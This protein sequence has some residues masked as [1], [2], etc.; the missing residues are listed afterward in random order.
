[1]IHI[2]STQLDYIYNTCSDMHHNN[3]VHNIC[4]NF[5]TKVYQYLISVLTNINYIKG[6]PKQIATTYT[7]VG[8]YLT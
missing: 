8:M 3:G 2:E 1:M 5:V 4:T 7:T 6:N